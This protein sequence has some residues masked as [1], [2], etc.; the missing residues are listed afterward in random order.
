MERAGGRAIGAR[1]ALASGR[2]AGERQ[3]RGAR[4]GSAADA[5]ARGAHGLGVARSWARG[6][7]VRPGCGLCT[8]CTWPIFD[9][10]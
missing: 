5:G 4:Q 2:R 3:A 6:L 10:F 8:R 7:G 1:G 9:P